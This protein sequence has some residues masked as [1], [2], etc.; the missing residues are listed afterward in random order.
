MRINY[1]TYQIRKSVLTCFLLLFFANSYLAAATETNLEKLFTDALDAKGQDYIE[2]RQKILSLS[3]QNDSYLKEQAKST[4]LKT[5]LIA[6]AI[7]DRAEKPQEYQHFEELMIVPVTVAVK[8][9]ATTVIGARPF[10]TIKLITQNNATLESSRG[11][12]T[13]GMMMP[14]MESGA[15]R[16]ILSQNYCHDE[17]A[18]LFLAEM[19]LKNTMLDVPELSEQIEWTDAQ[20]TYTSNEAAV[21]LGVLPQTAEKWYQAG[22]FLS[23]RNPSGNQREFFPLMQIESIEL[24]S[25]ITQLQIRNFYEYFSDKIINPEYLRSNQPVSRVVHAD[26]I[27]AAERFQQDPGSLFRCYAVLMLENFSKPETPELLYEVYK[28]DA[29][30]YVRAYCVEGFSAKTQAEQIRLAMKDFSIRVE[31]NGNRMPGFSTGYRQTETQTIKIPSSLVR[32]AAVVK[33]KEN[34]NAF[35]VSDYIEAIIQYIYHQAF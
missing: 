21:I 12:T 1:G 32:K 35:G 19:A 23:Q 34:P 7:L 14:E 13:S 25:P 26:T 16:Q 31:S 33:S 18:F 15:N 20:K 30:D 3:P 2:L 22:L 10:E 17:S 8:N 29:S 24:N 11:G 4:D 6:Q 28:Q 9:G 5:R 27:Y